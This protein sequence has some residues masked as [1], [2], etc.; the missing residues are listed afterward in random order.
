M[1]LGQGYTVEEQIT[2]KAEHG[3]LQFN[4]FLKPEL[5][6]GSFNGIGTTGYEGSFAIHMTPE[7]LSVLDGAQ[8]E[9]VFK[10]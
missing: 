8:I 10:L 9:F 5:P 7:E 4:I 3:G 1:P 2:G 6:P